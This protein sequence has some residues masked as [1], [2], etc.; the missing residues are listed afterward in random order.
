MIEAKDLVNV[1][2][3]YFK[4]EDGELCAPSRPFGID[5]I[6]EEW[7]PKLDGHEFQP[8]VAYVLENVHLVGPNLAGV[9]EDGRDLLLDVGYFGR[10][11]LWE[12]NKPYWGWAVDSLSAHSER[13]PC[14]MSMASVWSGNYFHW[15]IDHLPTVQ[16]AMEYYWRTDVPPTLLLGHNPPAFVTDSLG[17]MQ[18]SSYKVIDH[19]HYIVD[20]LI[21]P[22]WPRE[23]G[24]VRRG[25]VDYLRDFLREEQDTPSKVYITRRNAEARRLTNEEEI[26]DM[27]IARGFAVV[28]MEHLS[29]QDQQRIAS[30]AS[31]IVGPHGAGLV[32]SA[33]AENC[34]VVEFV[35]PT[36]T[37][38][39]IWLLSEAAQN[40]H[41]YIIGDPSIDDTYSVDQG[42]I[43]DVLDR[44]L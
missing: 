44:F 18:I 38:P 36:Y 4:Y 43:A 15:M 25:A 32:N 13:I 6:P 16:A 33:S 31:V 23:N 21:V 1:A 22:A 41:A 35:S 2:S 34:K 11:D 7:K 8:A 39:C 26:E 20:K 17:A 40:R 27:M 9:L 5:N 3:L 28:S 14:A 24:F 29:F 37:N 42:K 12:R 30:S 10:L 19:Y